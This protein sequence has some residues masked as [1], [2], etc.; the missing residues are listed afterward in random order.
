MWELFEQA[1]L[2]RFGH[3]TLFAW[4]REVIAAAW[5]KGSRVLLV[6]PT[7]GG[8][9][10]TY[11]LP[12]TLLA[13]TTLVISPLVALMEDQVASLDRR[14]IPGTW[15]ASTIPPDVRREREAWMRR[16]RYKIVYVAP[17]RLTYEPFLRTLAR[18]PIPLVAVDEAHCIVHWGREFRP[19]YAR[20]GGALE[21]LDVPRVMACT[22]TATPAVRHE[23]V[24]GLRFD[25]TRMREILC[26]F[27]RPNLHLAARWISG[28]RAA[29]TETECALRS[30][31]GEP[32][33]PAGGAIVYM[34]TRRA[35][36]QMA[37]GLRR[38]RWNVAPYHAGLEPDVRAETNAR[39]AAGTL[40]V[41]VATNA[42]GMGIDRADVRLVVHGQPPPSLDAYYQEVGR[43]GRDGLA[44]HGLLL[45]SRADVALRRR[46]CEMPSNGQPPSAASVDRAWW[47]FCEVLNFLD[48]RT[49]R[50]DSLMRYFGDHGA[51][52]GG[53][54]RCDVCIARSA[55][56][57]TAPAA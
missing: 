53:C 46:F 30:A 2:E 23:I 42:F 14:G 20:L 51:Q 48:E 3:G 47:M 4:Q 28:A 41:V 37:L 24:A 1:L 52:T 34:A 11:Q 13:G 19:E 17:E 43:A 9:S 35:T 26:G 45:C 38:R 57:V 18:V 22:A 54:G 8:K 10:L 29:A 7:G 40:D 39:F 49:C 25:R 50:H 32:A 21:R 31:L 33:R 44:A 27:A 36:E 15:L 56:G 12:A 55:R 6:A 5:P 16:G